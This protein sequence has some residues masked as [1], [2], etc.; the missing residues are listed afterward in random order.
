M[1]ILR[2]DITHPRGRVYFFGDGQILC[3]REVDNGFSGAKEMKQRVR[4][5]M[6]PGRTLGHSDRLP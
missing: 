2:D 1:L 5:R 6:D 3:D 4:D